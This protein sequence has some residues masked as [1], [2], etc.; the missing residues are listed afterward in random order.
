MPKDTWAPT[1][2]QA[3]IKRAR[4]PRQYHGKG[5]G[6]SAWN[7]I[8][9][10]ARIATRYSPSSK[11]WFGRHK[12]TEISKIPQ[13]YLAWLIRTTEPGKFWRM[14][15]LVLFLRKYLAETHSAAGHY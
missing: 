15:G 11:L 12:N 8:K 3:A 14:D 4:P 5:L 9:D 6:K 10:P 13:D 7:T 1:K 2:R